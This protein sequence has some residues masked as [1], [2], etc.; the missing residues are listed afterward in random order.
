MR[1]ARELLHTLASVV[2]HNFLGHQTT[3]LR[4]NNN[5]QKSAPHETSSH[6]SLAVPAAC[7]RPVIR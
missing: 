2:A 3:I 5:E 7:R 6:G 1:A 4:G